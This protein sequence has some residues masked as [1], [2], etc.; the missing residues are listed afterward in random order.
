M[1]TVSED[2]NTL[3]ENPMS[4][5]SVETAYDIEKEKHLR[6]NVHLLGGVANLGIL[7]VTV[8][9]ELLKSLA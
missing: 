1:L 4:V 3:K 9:T 2:S 8:T 6:K 5:P 7:F